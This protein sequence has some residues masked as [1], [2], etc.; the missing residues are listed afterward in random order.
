MLSLPTCWAVPLQKAVNKMAVPH[1]STMTSRDFTLSDHDVHVWC[2][3]LQQPTVVVDQLTRILSSDEKDHAARYHFEHLQRSFIVARG[4][5]RVLLGH[6]LH[7]QPAQV[8]FT[9]LRE[10]KPQLSERHAQKV[11]FNL[12]HSHELVLY[13]FSSSRN[14]GID[15]EHIRP[16]EDLEL[17]AEHNFST[18]EIAE[19]K[20]L[21]SHHK[22]DGFFNCWTRKEAYIKAIGNGVSFPLQQFD[23]S[24]NP[25]EPAKLLSILGSEQEAAHWSMFELHPA[26]GYTAALVVQGSGCEVS[27][28][29]CDQFDPLLYRVKEPK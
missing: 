12:S 18:R 16:M 17:I 3:S 13:S 25:G 21:S 2:A 20:K 5:L 8:E 6:Y 26:N 27:Y 10:G 7:I 29:E 23:V 22:L 4:I 19:L 14:I 28:R 1:T 9:Y 11:S 15:V 24:L